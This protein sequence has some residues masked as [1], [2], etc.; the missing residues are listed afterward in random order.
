MAR[1]KI[2]RLTFRVDRQHRSKDRPQVITIE[3]ERFKFASLADQFRISQQRTNK[4]L[5][6][7]FI[8]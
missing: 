4:P 2:E 5:L 8:Q 1:M 3:G 7:L 6:R